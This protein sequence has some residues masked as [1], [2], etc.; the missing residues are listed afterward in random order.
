MGEQG[1]SLP[2]ITSSRNDFAPLTLV[3]PT[4]HKAGT[5]IGLKLMLY[6]MTEKATLNG[7]E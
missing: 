1:E 5:A 4:P 3:A 6:H 7:R 2:T